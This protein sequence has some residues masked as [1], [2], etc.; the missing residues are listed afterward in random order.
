MRILFACIGLAV[1]GS[2]CELP[3]V[4][5]RSDVCL[6]GRTDVVAVMPPDAD[7]GPLCE[8]PVVPL[9]TGCN[10]KIALIDVD[11][12]LVNEERTGL[13]SLGQNPVGIFREKLDY[14][15]TRPGFCGVVLRINTPGGGV[16]A[17]DMMT[18]ELISFKQR[19]GLPVVALLMDVGAGGGY[20]LATACDLIVAHPTTITGGIGVI[21]NLYNLDGFVNTYNIIP[22]PIKS[23]KHIDVGSPFDPP[24]KD[25]DGDGVE[26]ER[27]TN[28]RRRILDDIAQQFHERFIEMV[29]QR[30]NLPADVPD[31]LFD[32]RI[33]TAAEALHYGLVDEIGYMDESFARAGELGGCPA[34]GVVMIH[35]H[36]DRAQSPY[37]ISAN[38][39]L[40]LL[41]I[42]IPGAD[43]SKLPT[44]MYLWQPEPRLGVTD[45]P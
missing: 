1:L 6:N 18:R 21:L 8:M 28:I 40:Q 33:F 23:G 2:G 29:K 22:R 16:T 27:I 12:L 43:R 4:K 35:R 45:K 41:P 14:V 39:P 25:E 37:D 13:F 5:T 20:Y 38:T 10:G 9:P 31:I 32:G 19:T 34:A 36:N 17:V 15:A 44:Y 30:R 7:H 3:V 24:V 42:N 26:L 11:G